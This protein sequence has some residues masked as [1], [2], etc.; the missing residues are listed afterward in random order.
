VTS[1]LSINRREVGVERIS[2]A[3]VA[4]DEARGIPDLVDLIWE[5]SVSSASSFNWGSHSD[6][7]GRRQRTQR[8]IAAP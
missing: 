1:H 8:N 5:L 7:G 6:W 3:Q 4:L 2:R